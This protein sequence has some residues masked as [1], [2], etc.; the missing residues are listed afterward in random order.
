[1]SPAQ[2]HGAEMLRNSRAVCAR[3]QEMRQRLLPKHPGLQP[4]QAHGPIPAAPQSAAGSSTHQAGK[5]SRR[6]CL[7]RGFGSRGAAAGDSDGQ[8]P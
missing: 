4:H 7:W 2:G 8:L 1:M 6:A 5:G 3:G